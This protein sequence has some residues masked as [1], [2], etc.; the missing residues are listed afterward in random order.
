MS[1]EALAARTHPE[2]GFTP[3]HPSP[4]TTSISARWYTTGQPPRHATGVP[5]H[6]L[7]CAG[8]AIPLAAL[9][10][11]PSKQQRN[12]VERGAIV[13]PEDVHVRALTALRQRP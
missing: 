13:L 6:L 10:R 3:H 5:T 11:T 8:F 12:A 1:P 9:G 4:L 7:L 2:R